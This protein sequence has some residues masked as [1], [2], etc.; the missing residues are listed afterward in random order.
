M[1]ALSILGILGL[2]PLS[3]AAQTDKD[4]RAYQSGDLIFQDL[5][6]GA[7]CDAIEA[8]TEGYKGAK[9][10]HVGLVYERNDSLFAIEAIGTAVQLT[11]LPQFLNRTTVNVHARLQPK[12]TPLLADA[13]AYCIDHLG[14]PYDEAFLYDNGKYYCSELL[15]DAFK[16]ANNNQPFFTLE[17]MTFKQPGTD[18]YYDVWIAYYQKLNMDIPEGQPGCNPGGL[19]RS[20]KLMILP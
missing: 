7:I 14:T 18:T 5:D 9:F 17:P 16:Y 4:G 3:L 8:V 10:S 11:Y 19:S 2:F 15:Y 1:K 20:D 6:C 13:L 12:Y